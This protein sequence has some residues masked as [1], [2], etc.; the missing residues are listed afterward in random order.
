MYANNKEELRLH[1]FFCKSTRS[2]HMFVLFDYCVHISNILGGYW[3]IVC[4]FSVKWTFP[5]PSLMEKSQ[6]PGGT[7]VLTAVC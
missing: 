4:V 1:L 7:S 5:L 2:G 3:A 6:Q